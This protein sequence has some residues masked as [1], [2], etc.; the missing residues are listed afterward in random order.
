MFE[1]DALVTRS[2][3]IETKYAMLAPYVFFLPNGRVGGPMRDSLRRWRMEDGAVVFFDRRGQ[4]T[5]RLEPDADGVLRGSFHPHGPVAMRPLP[6]KP[7][8]CLHQPAPTGPSPRRRNL[9][10][11]RCGP[12]SLHSQWT[13]D[14]ADAE[15]NWDLCLS[16]YGAPEAA[17]SDAEQV[18]CSRGSKFEGLADF[19][20]NQHWLWSYDYIWM[21]DDDLMTGWADINRMFGICA[22]YDLLLAQP[23]LAPES[24]VNQPITQRIDRFVLRFTSFVEIMAPVF[25]RSALR[26][27]APTFSANRTGYGLDHV[28]PRLIGAGPCQVAVIDAASVIHTRPIGTQYSMSEA[29]GEGIAVMHA[30]GQVQRYQVF[31]GVFANYSGYVKLRD[32]VDDPPRMFTGEEAHAICA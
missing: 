29:V 26:L 31:G 21:P 12:G 19:V 11:L 15:R 8:H 25:A 7:P 2:W 1:Q 20:A 14:I 18:V 9:V 22:E 4:P 3:S 13:R 24:F 32:R 27:C 28:W 17:P 16:W 5:A 10:V 30:F 6:V 23:A